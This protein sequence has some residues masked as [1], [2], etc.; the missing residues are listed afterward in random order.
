MIGIKKVEVVSLDNYGKIINSFDTTDDKTTNA[1]SINAVEEKLSDINSDI[2][3]INNNV[4]ALSN[5]AMLKDK[6]AVLYGYI[7][8]PEA[9]A[10]STQGTTTIS[11]PSGFTMHNSAVISLMSWKT[12]L[13]VPYYTTTMHD[14]SQAQALGSNGLSCRMGETD[15]MVVAYKAINSQASY[16]IRFRIVLMKIDFDDISDYELGD[17]NMDGEVTEADKTLLQN[18]LNNNG[19]LTGKQYKLADMNEDGVLDSFDLL[20]LQQKINS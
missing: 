16:T 4:T 10:S 6:F 8:M 13:S 1:P 9:N 19:S 18:Y 15:I 11:L 3:D 20:L 14:T 12:S 7:T 17:I 5:S 2:T